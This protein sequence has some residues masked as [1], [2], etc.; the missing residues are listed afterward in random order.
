VSEQA[1]RGASSPHPKG[2]APPALRFVEALDRW[3]DTTLHASPCAASGRIQVTAIAGR[4][5]EPQQ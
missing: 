2:M 4:W 3:T 5:L 1:R